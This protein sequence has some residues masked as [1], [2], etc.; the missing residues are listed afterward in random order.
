MLSREQIFYAL[1]AVAKSPPADTAQA[2]WLIHHS[3]SADKLTDMVTLTA[4]TLFAQYYLQL[5]VW[6]PY[7]CEQDG[8]YRWRHSLL[9]GWGGLIQ[10]PGFYLNNPVVEFYVC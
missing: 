6:G 5:V 7:S 10:M 4:F 2:F 9:Y 3:A 8:R 1:D